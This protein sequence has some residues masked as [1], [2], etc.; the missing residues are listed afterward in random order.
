MCNLATWAVKEG[1]GKKQHTFTGRKLKT[2]GNGEKKQHS[3]P[4]LWLSFLLMA[5][6]IACGRKKN[7]LPG[8]NINSEMV[9]GIEK[10]AGFSQSAIKAFGGSI[11]PGSFSNYHVPAV[12]IQPA[13]ASQGGE[14]GITP[15]TG[16]AI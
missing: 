10:E 16:F 8:S 3:I 14:A 7:V 12:T 15:I 13:K 9:R 2:K 1:R 6:E 4:C 5:W 11:S